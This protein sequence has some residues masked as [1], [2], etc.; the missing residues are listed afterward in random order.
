MKSTEKYV[1]FIA[2]LVSTVFSTELEYALL[3][4]MLLGMGQSSEDQ[5][6][7]RCAVRTRLFY[8]VLHTSTR[9]V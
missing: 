8:R 3:L 1:E 4:K 2:S 9:D 6:A 5:Y 7:V